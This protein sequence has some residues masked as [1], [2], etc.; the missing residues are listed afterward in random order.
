MRPKYFHCAEH[1]KAQEEDTCVILDS[2]GS[3]DYTD[4]KPSRLLAALAA[5]LA[6]LKI[7]LEQYPSDRVAVVAFGSTA[8]EIHPLLEVGGNLKQFEG[9]LKKLD[10]DGGTNVT[11]GLQKAAELLGMGI[12]SYSTP[13]LGRLLSRLLYE[14]P[15]TSRDNRS[16]PRR[17]WRMVLLSDGAH[18]TGVGPEGISEAI[19]Q[20]GCVIDVI[21]IGG[22]PT[23]EEFEESRL[24]SLAAYS[25]ENDQWFRRIPFTHSG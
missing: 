19:R 6:M 25:G 16:P 24:K 12:V 3:M 2:S 21:G 9:A 11:A 20:S 13:R 17:Q 22:S 8:L 10:A 7:K 14:E 1:A 4:Y 15:Q 5:V 23:A 18:N